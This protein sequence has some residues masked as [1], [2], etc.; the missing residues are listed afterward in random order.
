M[1]ISLILG[2]VAGGVLLL[3]DLLFLPYFPDKLLKT[4][5]ETTQ[6]ENLTA[7]FY[8]GINEGL[9]C[10]LFGIS[11]VAWLLSQIWHT[12]AG[13]PTTGIFWIA[14]FTLALLFALGHLPAQKALTGNITSVMLARTL[15]LNMLVGLLCGWLFWNYGILAAMIAHFAVDIVYHVGGTYVLRLKNQ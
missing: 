3:L 9:L 12:A 4:A 2:I 5:L 13:L 15:I 14:N 8:G 1:I 7:S 10:R 6:L 11:A